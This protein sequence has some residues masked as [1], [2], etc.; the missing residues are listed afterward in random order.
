[1]PVTLADFVYAVR[2]T[3][4]DNEI[5]TGTAPT[6]SANWSAGVQSDSANGYMSHATPSGVTALTTNYT[7][8]VVMDPNEAGTLWRN[9]LSVPAYSSGSHTSPF[10]SVGIAANNSTTQ[11]TL[12]TTISNSLNQ[13]ASA[14]AAINTGSDGQKCYAVR[15][16]GTAVDYIVNGVVHSSGTF[17]SGGD[18]DF[19]PSGDI[20]I[21]SRSR[22]SPGEGLA[23]TYVFVG[24]SNRQLTDAELVEITN[25]PL[26]FEGTPPVTA[27]LSATQ[28]NQTSTITA[29]VTITGT[30]AVVQGDQSCTIHAQRF[31]GVSQDRIEPGPVF[32]GRT[33]RRYFNASKNPVTGP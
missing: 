4:S 15:R 14:T 26:D 21:G 16:N 22:T 25:A 29:A 17:P 20:T 30:I 13:L 10:H 27:T 9:M 33:R 1:M 3:A 24:I 31:G 18:A 2:P 23:G 12:F 7:L 5:I 8:V 28:T 11:L 19:V 6:G 32:P